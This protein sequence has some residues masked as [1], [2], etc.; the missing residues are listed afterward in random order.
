MT[1][2]IDWERAAIGWRL[3]KAGDEQDAANW[4]YDQLDD[5]LTGGDE[6][7]AE[8]ERLRPALAEAGVVLEAL[9]ASVQWELAPEVKAE[10]SRVLRG[11]RAALMK[12]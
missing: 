3:A 10:I 6:L 4:A 11:V 9:H 8:N 12:G 5:L 7:R 2:T 1:E